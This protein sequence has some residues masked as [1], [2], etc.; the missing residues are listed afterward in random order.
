MYVC[1]Y[2][3]DLPVDPMGVGEELLL[4]EGLLEEGGLV[5]PL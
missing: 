5:A 1:M 4:V 2:M 3:T